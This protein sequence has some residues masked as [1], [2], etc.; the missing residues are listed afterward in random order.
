LRFGI[1]AGKGIAPMKILEA[2]A[3]LIGAVIA[4]F[5][6]CAFRITGEDD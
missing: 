6:W 4:L 2:A 3:A 5:F 1:S